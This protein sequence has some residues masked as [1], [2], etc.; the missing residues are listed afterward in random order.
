MKNYAII[1]FFIS[2]SIFSQNIKA[3]EKSAL[4]D[5]E[6]A[7]Q[8]AVDRNL[9]TILKYTHPKIHK[10]YGQ[11]ELMDT[12]NEIFKTMDAQNI[13][14]LTSKVDEISD[15]KQE[16]KEFHCLAKTTTEM[17]FNGRPI[18][19]KSSLFGFYNKKKSQ[20]HFVESNKLLEDPETQKI[21]PKFKTEIKIPEDE[22]ITDN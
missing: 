2:G 17:N 15:I 6:A 4:Q 12:M 14:I 16:N 20:W 19:L 21:F 10:V 9:S 5:A 11:S 8:A 7:T 3:L 18:T 22:H 13:K 1:L